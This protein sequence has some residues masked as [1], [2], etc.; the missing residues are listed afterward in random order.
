MLFLFLSSQLELSLK[1]KDL[2]LS[3]NIRTLFYEVSSSMETNR[4]S[5]MFP[6]KRTVENKTCHMD[7]IAR[8]FFFI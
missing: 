2:F 7:R 6:S 8:H 3:F 4:K 5:Q 1:R